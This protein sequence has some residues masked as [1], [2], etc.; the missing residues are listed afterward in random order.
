MGNDGATIERTG[1][2]VLWEDAAAGR[3]GLDTPVLWMDGAAAAGLD[4]PGADR[5]HRERLLAEGAC[6]GDE[7][8]IESL[9]RDEWHH[10]HKVVSGSVRD[11]VAAEELTLE[12]FARAIGRISHFPYEQT[13]FRSYVLQSAR[14]ILRDRRRAAQAG[15][16]EAPGVGSAAPPAVCDS[17]G[18]VVT[19]EVEPGWAGAHRFPAQSPKIEIEVEVETSGTIVLTA[20]HRRQ[21]VAALDRLP[22][23]Y[24]EALRLRL[25][26]GRSAVEIGADWGRTPEDVRR[27]QR[28]AL[29][30]LRAEIEGHPVR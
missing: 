2:E 26:E 15:R 30:M 25:L 21:L 3:P 4:A 11:P 17:F 29:Q 16:E 8:S 6:L 22:D 19:P 1:L 9:C 20:N 28:E 18:K 14:C 23:R 5:R 24:R 13:S 10:V 27:V 7:G 12:A